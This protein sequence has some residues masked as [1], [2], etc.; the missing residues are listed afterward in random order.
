MAIVRPTMKRGARKLGYAL[1]ALAIDFGN[2]D[3]GLLGV[4]RVGTSFA[5]WS[6]AIALGVYGFEAH[7]AV[8]VGLV[9]LVRFLPGAVASPFAGLLIDR[10][11]RRMVLLASSLAMGAVLAGATVAASLGAPS[12]VVFVFPALFAVASCAYGP[13]E[14]ALIPGLALTPQELSASNVTHSA[15]ENSG[16]LLAAI[17]TGILLGATSPGFVFGVATGVTALATIVIAAVRRDRRPHYAA[18]E[19][20]V[21]GVVREIGLGLRTLVEHPALRLSAATLIALL[22]FEGFA[23]VLVVVMALELLHLGEGSVGFLNASW[24]L[25]ALLGGA[26]L[27]LLLDRGKLVIAIAGGSLVL[28]LA[29]MLPGIWPERASAY[30]GWLGIGIGF[31]FVEVAA[32]TLMQRLGSDETLGRVIG[33][34]ESA[35]LAAMALGSIGAIG[36]IEVLGT[37]GALI[38]LGALM[39]VFVVVC[40]ARLRAFEVGAPVA[41]GPYLLLRGNSIFAPLPIATLERLSHDLVAVEAGAGE[42]VIV[43]GEA[44]DRFFLIEQGEVEVFENGV[45]RRNEGPGESFGEIALLHDVPRTATVRATVETRLLALEREQFLVAVAGHSRSRQVAHTV[46]D[47]RW[48]GQDLADVS[49]S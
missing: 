10:Y 38:A 19:G 29:T 46:S 28:G 25:G 18:D 24:G 20:E 32:K 22:L 17:V 49:R 4:A 36:L 42:E 1:R 34:L 27:A 5:N 48:D 2:R 13:A 43:Q 7:G 45:F 12:A 47:D 39:P 33:S 3:L 11:P 15:M 37:R 35:R 26:G 41:E 9:A 14:S 44:G 31:T 8:G 6:F 23:D 21:A 40:W 16:F 30:V